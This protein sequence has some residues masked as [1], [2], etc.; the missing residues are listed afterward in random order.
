MDDG[1]D[2]TAAWKYLTPQD[3]ALENGKFYNIKF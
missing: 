3:C 2:G 1:D